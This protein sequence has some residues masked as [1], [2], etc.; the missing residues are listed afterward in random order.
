MS[1]KLGTPI[2]ASG[3]APLTRGTGDA[4]LQQPEQMLFFQTKVQKENE[5]IVRQ[6]KYLSGETREGKFSSRIF[7]TQD[8]VKVVKCGLSPKNKRSPAKCYASICLGFFA[9]CGH[10][11]ACGHGTV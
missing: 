4:A 10:I 3:K 9:F 8:E 2:K 11:N 6:L 5:L 7:L 1:S